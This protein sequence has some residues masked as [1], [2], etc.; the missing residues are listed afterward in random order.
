MN[1]LEAATEALVGYPIDWPATAGWV[2]AWG[3]IAAILASS[4]VAVLV[5]IHMKRLDERT[6]VQRAINTLIVGVGLTDAAIQA[7][8]QTLGAMT[9]EEHTKVIVRRQIMSARAAL[10]AV[11]RSM[12]LVG[13]FEY[14][15]GCDLH[16]VTLEHIIESVGGVSLKAR[17]R[18]KEAL[19]A[20][21][22][23]VE[24]ISDAAAKLS[25]KRFDGIWMIYCPE[26][27]PLIDEARQR[28][29]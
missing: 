8:L 3:S 2:Q 20:I 12:F 19:E 10:D 21:L 29:Q 9:F 15:A 16:L 13:A 5:P 7:T 22:P 17:S 28:A 14:V 25:P 4:A 26:D 27:Q 6:I 24:R 18:A 23:D 1:L 11:P